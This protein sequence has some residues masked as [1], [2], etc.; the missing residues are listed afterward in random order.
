MAPLASLWIHKLA[1]F[2]EGGGGVEGVLL[3][4]GTT[5]PGFWNLL[6]LWNYFS[7]C[8]LDILTPVP[9]PH[10]P[11]TS[12]LLCTLQYCCYFWQVHVVYMHNASVLLFLT[13]TSCVHVPCCSVVFDRAIA[14]THA[15]LQCCFWQ[16]HAVYTHNTSVGFLTGTCCVHAPCFSVVVFDSYTLCTWTVLPCLFFDRDTLCTHAMLQCCFWQGHAVYTHHASVLLFLAGTRRVHTPCFSVVF[17]RH[18]L[19]T[20]TMPQCCFWQGHAVYTHHASVLFLTGTRCVHTP[21]LSVVVFDRDTLCT[22]TTQIK[23]GLNCFFC[24]VPYNIITFEASFSNLSDLSLPLC[25]SLSVSLSAYVSTPPPPMPFHSLPSPS[26]SLSS[27]P[28]PPLPP[29]SCPHL[30]FPS[31]YLSPFSAFP[32]LRPPSPSLPFAPLSVCLC[33]SVSW[34]VTVSMSLSVCLSLSLCLSLQS[35]PVSSVL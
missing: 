31:L 20:R 8:C 3:L 12:S 9:P 7:P 30:P 27:S 25:P 35:T 13:G 23:E 32:L 1:L 6:Q 11:P 34:S 21:C 14:C 19:C 4:I 16:L 2:F 22:R 10:L 26:H 5:F 17:D 15:M 24:L 29:S 28:L 33:L 18:M